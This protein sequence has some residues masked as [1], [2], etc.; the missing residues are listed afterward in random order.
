[1]TEWI[2]ASHFEPDQVEV[3]HHGIIHLASEELRAEADAKDAA[4]P[5]P[6]WTCYGLGQLDDS[7]GGYQF[8]MAGWAPGAQPARQPAGYAIPLRPGD[9]LIV[10]V[11]YHFDEGAAPDLSRMVF[12]L[13]SD[14]DLAAAGGSFDSLQGALYLGPAEIPCYE[15]DTDPLCDREVALER[16]RDLYGEFAAI[17]PDYF[18]GVCRS[19]PA[20]YA[21]MT[22][23]TAWSTCDLPVENPGRIVSVAGHMHELGLSIRL[24]LNPGTPDEVV[25]LDIPNWNFEWQFGY[26]PVDD[27][28]IGRGDTI[29]I[30]CAWNRERAPYEAVGYVLWADGTGDEMCY[31]NITTAPLD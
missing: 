29:R 11:H 21:A 28:I 3:V 12:D 23:G 4:E 8:R 20:D 17:L 10:Q 25:L 30:D 6:G 16:V 15:G 22:D 5:G 24:T 26:Q 2:L 9:F 14:D 18:L 19:R 7:N 31:S 13:A 1:E 27:I